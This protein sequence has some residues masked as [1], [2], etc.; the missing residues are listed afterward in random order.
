MPTMVLGFG[1][2]GVPE[3]VAGGAGTHNH[4][5]VVAAAQARAD[6]GG[7]FVYRAPWDGEPAGHEQ[8]DAAEL[9]AVEHAVPPGL[10]QGAASMKPKRNRFTSGW[11]SSSSS[12][13]E[14][15]PSVSRTTFTS[16]LAVVD[17]A[18]RIA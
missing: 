1:R 15:S 4:L 8:G 6:G 10:G 18:G 5:R 9:I 12:R 17:M 2:P 13:A 16:P 7:V 14:L 3:G 11:V